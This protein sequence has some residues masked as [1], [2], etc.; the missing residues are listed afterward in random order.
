MTFE[1]NPDWREQTRQIPEGRAPQAELTV[2][3]K[4]HRLECAFLVKEAR[5]PEWRQKWRHM[6][7]VGGHEAEGPGPIL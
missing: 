7:T 3:M 5:R 2:R 4:A 1:P 6:K